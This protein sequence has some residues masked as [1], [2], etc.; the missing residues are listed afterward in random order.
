M[1][2][3]RALKSV[4]GVV[5]LADKRPDL[6]I[7]W[8]YDKNVSYCESMNCGNYFENGGNIIA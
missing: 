7:D 5:T 8:D 1:K 6:L 2:G 3:G 4:R